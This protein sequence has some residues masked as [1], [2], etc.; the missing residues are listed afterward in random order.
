MLENY[1]ITDLE[2]TNFFKSGGGCFLR[3][4]LK[5]SKQYV[6]FGTELNDFSKYRPI[7]LCFSLGTSWNG[8]RSIEIDSV[9]PSEFSF[10]DSYDYFVDYISKEFAEEDVWR[11]EQFKFKNSKSKKSLIEWLIYY[12]EFIDKID[13]LSDEQIN[14]MRNYFG[15]Y[16]ALDFL[17]QKFP[18]LKGKKCEEKSL[19][20]ALYNNYGFEVVDRIEENPYCFVN[21]GYFRAYNFKLAEEIANYIGFKKD[22]P[23]RIKA[24]FDETFK[25]AFKKFSGDTAFLLNQQRVSWLLNCAVFMSGLCFSERVLDYN[26]FYYVFFNNDF[27]LYKIISVNNFNYLVDKELNEN[28]VFT[29]DYIKDALNNEPL[30]NISKRKIDNRIKKFE[31]MES[32]E[33]TDEQIEAIH[34]SINNR[35]S[36]ITGGPGCGKTKVIQAILYIVQDATECEKVVTSYT[37]KALKRMDEVL[38]DCVFPINYHK[39]TVLSYYYQPDCDDEHPYPEYIKKDSHINNMFVVIDE[40]SMVSQMAF[41]QFLSVLNNCQLVVIGDCDQLP[42][43]D[44]GQ[45]LYDI[46]NFDKVCV[47]RLTKNLRLQTLSN[48]LRDKM[49]LNYS[50]ILNND[51]DSLQYIPNQFSWKFV[52]EHR[53]VDVTHKIIDDY[54]SYI[55]GTNGKYKVDIED[56]CILTPTKKQNSLLSSTTLN[57]YIQRKINPYG[58]KT[59]CGYGKDGFIRVDDRVILTKNMKEDGVYNG[60]IGTVIDFD[61]IYITVK[62]D[63]GNIVD[64]NYE[65]AKESLELAYAMTVHKS[66]GSEYKVVLFAL[67]YSINFWQ[68]SNDLINKNLIYTAITRTKGTV[69]FYGSQ[70]VLKYGIEHN[71]NSRFT[72][73]PQYLAS[74]LV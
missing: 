73:L 51:Y 27:E 52:C 50:S 59:F 64:F 11:M 37:G 31:K 24:I 28:E 26:L 46:I 66:Q 41:G 34:N 3:N 45:V 32:I 48:K 12:P 63:D 14:I 54:M 36:V 67:D 72:L 6:Y 10:Y 25:K 18:P 58:E 30:V 23:L 22:S 49:L 15:K 5:K 8:N 69:L 44:R 38:R 55:N 16:H 42:S 2:I 74:D 4:S 39:S 1:I 70:N 62:F 65:K 33:F 35:F 7:K 68:A 53:E 57:L 9:L 61:R 17:A 20:E 40:A 19:I 43:I 71:S 21:Y 56:I 47:S 60:D 13:F 29:A